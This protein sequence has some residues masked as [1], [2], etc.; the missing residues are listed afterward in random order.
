VAAVGGLLAPLDERGEQQPVCADA[1]V[2]AL[3]RVG[4]PAVAVD[5]RALHEAEAAIARANP[6][7]RVE[8]EEDTGVAGRVVLPRDRVASAVVAVEEGAVGG[9]AALE[10]RHRRAHSP[11]CV[12]RGDGR[13]HLRRD[14]D[15]PEQDRA[16]DPDAEVPERPPR[17]EQSL[18]RRQSGP[19]RPAYKRAGSHRHRRFG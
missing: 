19:R 12:G 7:G 11:A 1:G 8:G 5:E 13:A 9:L 17:H 14:H 4:R 15:R 2:V 18:R 16:D 10:P 3:P 6:P